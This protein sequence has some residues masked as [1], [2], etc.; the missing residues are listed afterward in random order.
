MEESLISKTNKPKRYFSTALAA[1]VIVI[2]IFGMA[3][4]NSSG[5]LFAPAATAAPTATS[6][7][8]PTPTPAGI[9]PD[10][11]LA[12]I[13]DAAAD[14]DTIYLAPGVFTL[15]KGINIS[16][17]L[18]IIGRGYDQTTITSG[19]PAQDVSAMITY[20]GS[21]TLTFQGVKILYTGSD[22]SAVVYAKSG[23]LSMND[24]YIEGATVSANGSQLGAVHL[25]D[26]AASNIKNCQI[27]GSTN[28]KDPKEPEKIPGGIILYGNTHLTVEDSEIFDSYMGIYA[29]GNADVTV[30]NTKIRNAYFGISLLENAKGLIDKNNFEGNQKANLVFFDKSLGS[31][32]ENSI[33][34]AKESIGVQVNEEANVLI[35]N[36]VVKNVMSAIL[37]LDNSTGDA[38]SNELSSFT[39]AGIMVSGTTAPNVE[40]NKFSNE[41]AES[42][43]IIYNGNA[44]GK[45]I[46]NIFSNLYLGI[47]LDE[48]AAP[49]LESNDILNCRT[50]IYYK[51]ESSG[52]A[53]QNSIDGASIGILIY[54]PAKPI[55]TN[56]TI[57]A[58]ENGL[59]SEPEDWIN[60]I[61]ASGNII[62]VGPPVVEVSTFTPHP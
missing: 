43:G 9:S 25:S 34:G 13:I 56:N 27:A 53:N 11:D 49:L 48:Q 24:C 61:S 1:V 62:Q 32:T 60:Q 29:F 17:T 45:A 54:S 15:E 22:P 3:S 7:P 55:L 38:I 16:K 52:T 58:L 30:R 51:G 41:N 36:N 8:L 14:G 10:Q 40:N 19:S 31:V 5:G 35:E 12:A 46:G 2:L 44:S 21:G 59:Q 47:S 42:I 6:T 18:T 4:C 39:N 57:S 26:D 50:G 23:T 28:R 20:S 37:F 33:S